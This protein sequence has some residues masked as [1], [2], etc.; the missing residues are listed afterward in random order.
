[1]KLPTFAFF[2]VAAFFAQMSLIAAD[3]S[4]GQIYSLTFVDVDGRTLFTADGHLTVVVV[5][6]L[7]ETDKA[8]VVGDR[9]PDY[10]LGNPLHQ[11]ITIIEFKK[12]RALARAFLA[13]LVRHRL[14]SEGEQLQ[15]R[16][17]RLNI[18]R[19]ARLDVH[20]VTD[21]DGKIAAQLGS[22][23]VDAVFR[24]FVFGRD[25]A[26]LKEWND[27]PTTEQLAAMLK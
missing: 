19:N 18:K 14:D 13:A 8:R 17:D 3:L 26:L 2:F 22:S 12:H 16:Y 5:T 25:G 4:N 23:N 7:A 1:V 21:F 24:V 15:K 9:V 10:C 20:A 6:T 27:V 11:L